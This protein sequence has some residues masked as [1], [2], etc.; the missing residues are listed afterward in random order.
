MEGKNVPTDTI[1]VS[2]GGNK[3]EILVLDRKIARVIPDASLTQTCY[4]YLNRMMEGGHKRV[5]FHRCYQ[6]NR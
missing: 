4:K 2:L 1:D 3:L 5:G 6:T